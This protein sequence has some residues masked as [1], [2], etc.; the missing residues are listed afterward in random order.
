MAISLS[1]NGTT[2]QIDVDGETPLLWVLRDHLNLTGTKYS[3]G[4]GKC[5]SCMV[6]VENRP[7]RSCL[8]TAAEAIGKDITTIE[9]LA[10]ES[11]HP[12]MRAWTDLQVPQ[13]GYCQS[14]QIVTAHALLQD[15]HAPSDEEI[16]N[17]MSAVLCRCGTYPRIRQAIQQAAEMMQDKEKP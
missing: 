4:I 5:G 12:V 9:G 1:I 13:C 14:G 17:A 6:L 7:V 3:C 15:N 2:T 10:K 16:D 8:L 11:Q